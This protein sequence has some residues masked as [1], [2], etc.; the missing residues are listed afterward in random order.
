MTF[1]RSEFKIFNNLETLGTEEI[2]ALL[3]AR[4]IVA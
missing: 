4:A 3:R 2:E 1:P